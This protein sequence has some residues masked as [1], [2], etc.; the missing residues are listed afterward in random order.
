MMIAMASSAGLMR[1]YGAESR[2]QKCRPMQP[3]TQT[4]TSS[5]LCMIALSG[6][7]FKSS[8]R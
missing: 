2:S 6:Q 5:T 1:R 4:M 8:Y 7:S 3:C